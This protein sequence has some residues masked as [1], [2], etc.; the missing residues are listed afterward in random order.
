MKI[1]VYDVADF[2][3][4]I[5]EAIRQETEDEIILTDK[6]LTLDTLEAAVGF[7]GISVLVY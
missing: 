4:D 2:E 1:Y 6:H 5:L 3:R 7:D